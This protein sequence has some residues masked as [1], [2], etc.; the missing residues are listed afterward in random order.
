MT[1]RG[2]IERGVVVLE[3]PKALPEGTVVEVS[4]VETAPQAVEGEKQPSW[5]EVFDDLIGTVE[6]L[7]ADFAQNH[8]HYIHGTPKR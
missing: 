5:G 8:D 4:P 6:G 7:P 2:R 3:D 1:L